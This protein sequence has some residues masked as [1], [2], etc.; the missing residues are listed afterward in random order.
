MSDDAELLSRFHGWAAEADGAF[1]VQRGA[2][3]PIDTKLRGVAIVSARAHPPDAQASVLMVRRPASIAPGGAWGF[4]SADVL[5]DDAAAGQ[6][7][8]SSRAAVLRTLAADLGVTVDLESAVTHSAWL[9]PPTVPERTCSWYFRLAGADPALD[10]GRDAD[11]DGVL[12]RWIEPRVALQ[13]H[14]EREIE[15]APPTW[16]T[17]H[18]LAF[19]ES[20]AH[21]VV[22]FFMLR[23]ARLGDDPVQLLPGDSGFAAGDPD[24]DGSRQRLHLHRLHRSGWVYERST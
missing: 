20:P 7:I 19:H 17:L 22:E 10:E 15:L 6:P 4:P 14:A 23:P 16:L 12:H 21:A 1:S 24:L 5:G 9:P 3:N 11:A 18:A 13:S 2:P 8:A